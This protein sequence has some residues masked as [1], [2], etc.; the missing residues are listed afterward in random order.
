MLKMEGFHDCIVGTVDVP[1]AD[2]WEEVLCYDYDLVIGKLMEDQGWS[3][4]DA[5]EYHWFNQR[6]YMGKGSPCFLTQTKE[7]ENEL[8]QSSDG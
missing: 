6:G 7:I 1:T 2:G 4:E 3:Y 8:I 5:V